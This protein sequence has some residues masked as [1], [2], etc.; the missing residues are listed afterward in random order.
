[1]ISKISD[2]IAKIND[3]QTTIA[4]AM[5][6]QTATTG[7]MS[8][9]IAV[10]ASGSGRIAEN[11]TDVANASADSLEG[12]IQ[13]RQASEEVARTAETLRGLVGTFT[14]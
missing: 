8:R 2:V 7:E 14:L 9:S 10:V 1:V 12:V 6:E 3:Y 4:S 13:T 5:E 11:I